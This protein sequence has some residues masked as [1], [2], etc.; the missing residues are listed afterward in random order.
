[1]RSPRVIVPINLGTKAQ[2][3]DDMGSGDVEPIL[4]GTIEMVR[5]DVL[6]HT[7]AFPSP[8]VL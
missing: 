1:M 2:G 8:L 7:V 6:A 5:S 4:R 3:K